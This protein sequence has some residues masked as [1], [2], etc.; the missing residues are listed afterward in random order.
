MIE[1]EAHRFP[2]DAAPL[3]AGVHHQAHSPMFGSEG[4][5]ARKVSS[6]SMTNPTSRRRGTTAPSSRDQPTHRL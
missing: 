5:A 2:A 1:D 6:A 4:G 3:M